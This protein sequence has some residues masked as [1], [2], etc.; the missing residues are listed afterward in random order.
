M[1]ER[2]RAES[3]DVERDWKIA[4]FPE[5]LGWAVVEDDDGTVDILKST[6]C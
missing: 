6:M 5:G 4:W 1:I 2:G 3:C